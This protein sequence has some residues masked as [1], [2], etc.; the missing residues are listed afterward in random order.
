MAVPGGKDE[1]AAPAMTITGPAT[2]EDV[3]AIIAVLAATGG[4]SDDSPA[5]Q[6][7]TWAAH[8]ATMRRPVRHGPAAWRTSLRP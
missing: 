8:S 5:R 6:T 1:A 3:A 2:A 4:G 7:S